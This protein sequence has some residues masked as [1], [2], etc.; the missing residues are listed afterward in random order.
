MHAPK[1]LL[2]EY[3]LI[4]NGHKNCLVISKDDVLAKYS[5]FIDNIY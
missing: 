4:F 1:N 5:E 2:E 3:D